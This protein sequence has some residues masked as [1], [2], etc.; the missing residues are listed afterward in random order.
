ME[1]LDVQRLW[2][3]GDKMRGV[4]MTANDDLAG[5]GKGQNNE[6]YDNRHDMEQTRGISGHQE[7]KGRDKDS[8]NESEPGHWTASG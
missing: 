8:I 1:L 7:H 5:R 4:G 6:K 2:W 3:H